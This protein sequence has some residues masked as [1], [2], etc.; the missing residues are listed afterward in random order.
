MKEHFVHGLRCEV[1]DFGQSSSIISDVYLEQKQIN[2]S[3]TNPVI[4]FFKSKEVAQS[5]FLLVALT[6]VTITYY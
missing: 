4:L 1:D 3:A 5:G 6:N 2:I